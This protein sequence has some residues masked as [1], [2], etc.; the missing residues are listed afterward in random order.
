MYKGL[1]LGLGLLLAASAFAANQGPLEVKENV[2]VAGKQLAA[3][4]YQ[5]KWEGT[6]PNVEVT[7]MKGKNLVATVPARLQDES[8]APAKNASVMRIN[9]DGS[10]SLSEIQFAGKKYIL[11]LGEESAKADSGDGSK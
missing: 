6:G 2:S 10:K 8:Q 1:F 5:L 4:T 7:I 11:A 9:G 3:G